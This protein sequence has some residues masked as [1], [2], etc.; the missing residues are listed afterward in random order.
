MHSWCGAWDHM[1]RKAVTHWATSPTDFPSKNQN[2]IAFIVA[3][4]HFYF[5]C[6]ILLLHLVSIHE[7]CYLHF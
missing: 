6:F 4:L 5:Y 1:L 7:C 2:L 3:E